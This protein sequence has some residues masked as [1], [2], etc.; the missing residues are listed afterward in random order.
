[1]NL[2]MPTR[3]ST[4]YKGIGKKEVI[5]IG[6]TA[7]I[8]LLLVA[9]A[10]IV[11]SRDL[12]TVL[13]ASAFGGMIGGLMAFFFYQKSSINLSVYDYLILMLRFSGAQKYFPYKKSKEW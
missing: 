4:R 13:I 12:Q 9:L 3:M 2:F 1:M 10:A 7:G 5:Q 8:I 6:V 11:L